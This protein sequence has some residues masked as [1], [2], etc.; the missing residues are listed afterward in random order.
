MICPAGSDPN[1]QLNVSYSSNIIYRALDIILWWL[2]SVW[3]MQ[4]L[5]VSYPL[6]DMKRDTLPPFKHF[7]IEKENRGTLTDAA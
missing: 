6:N 3:N 4:I 5:L 1:S 7:Y 2:I